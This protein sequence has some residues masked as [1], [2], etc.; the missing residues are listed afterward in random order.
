MVRLK[1]GSEVEVWETLLGFPD[2]ENRFHANFHISK[3][4]IDVSQVAAL[5]FTTE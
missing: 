5:V 2:E 3:D 4:F 1:D